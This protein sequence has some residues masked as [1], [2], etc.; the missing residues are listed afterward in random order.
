MPKRWSC[1]SRTAMFLLLCS[2]AACGIFK[3]DEETQAI[4]NRRIVGI[5]IG[6]FADAFGSPDRRSP[7]VDGT[8]S[9]VWM[10]RTGPASTGFAPLDDVR[11]VLAIVADGRGRIVTAQVVRDDLG[12]GGASRC[13]AVFKAK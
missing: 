3:T 8:T 12:Q 5:S 4:I 13:D 9:F 1:L 10:S 7:Q 6:D 2:V 11:C